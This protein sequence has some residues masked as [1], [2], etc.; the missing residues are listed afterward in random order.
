[1]K[2]DWDNLF[3]KHQIPPGNF[4]IF[5]L[6]RGNPELNINADENLAYAA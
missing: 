5:D 6:G 1:M 3:G 4:K 2:M